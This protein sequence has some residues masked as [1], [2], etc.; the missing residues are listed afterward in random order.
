MRIARA[1]SNGDRRTSAVT[2]TNT[3]TA[4]FTIR[5][6]PVIALER[7]AESSLACPMPEGGTSD[8][9][10]GSAPGPAQLQCSQVGFHHHFN[11]L[12]EIHLGPPTQNLAR[13]AGIAAKAIYFR[14][15]NQLGIY[16]NVFLPAQSGKRKGCF[17]QF[18]NA[19]SL[20]GGDHKIFRLRL[21][22]HQ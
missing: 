12:L 19:V 18:L 15:T 16:F 4:R 22:E 2:A 20:A 6:P 13:F 3:S 14:G 7:A 8:P 1:A 10:T 11:E 5:A 21:L 17:Q 9:G